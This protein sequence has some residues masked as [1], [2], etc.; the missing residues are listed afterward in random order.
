MNLKAQVAGL[1][2]QIEALSSLLEMKTEDVDIHDVPGQIKRAAAAGTD[3][4]NMILVRGESYEMRERMIK[5]AL[6]AQVHVTGVEQFVEDYE[7]GLRG[8]QVGTQKFKDEY[9]GYEVLVIENLEQLA[10][11]K[12]KLQ[13]QLF[14]RVYQRSEEGKLTILSGNAAFIIGTESEEY[15]HMLSLGKNVFVG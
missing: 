8:G 6:D 9:D 15:L 13:E 2:Q 10:G 7:A 1:N 5:E 3:H 12:A 4:L 14:D 11:D